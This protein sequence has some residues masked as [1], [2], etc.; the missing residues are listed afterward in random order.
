M[1]KLS[2]IASC[3]ILMA[4]I[5]F[6]AQSFSL[7]AQGTSNTSITL[8]SNSTFV[9][10]LNA[11]VSGFNA[12]GFSVW[13]QATNTLAPA[14]SLTSFTVF[15]F[16]DK[17]QPIVPKVFDSASG[18]DAGF[19]SDRQGAPSGDLGATAN[20]PSQDFVGTAHLADYTFSI[21]NVAPGT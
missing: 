2:I 17:T 3:L 7:V 4:G 21:G 9:L 14:L 1:K 20:D 15:Q 8:N 16:P 13:L 10:T 19:L 12:D 18:A 11:T 6:G 5:S